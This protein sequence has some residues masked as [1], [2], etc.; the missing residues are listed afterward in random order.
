MLFL[1]IVIGLNIIIL[2]VCLEDFNKRICDD[3]YAPEND[4]A[5]DKVQTGSSHWLQGSTFMLALP[6][7]VTAQFLGSWSDTFGRKI[8]MLLPPI[9]ECSTGCLLYCDDY[10]VGYY[11]HTEKGLYRPCQRMTAFD[12]SVILSSMIFLV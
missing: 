6:S 2:Q 4:L 3:L 9:G 12:Y 7:I 5:L 10:R 1:C 8:P 11:S